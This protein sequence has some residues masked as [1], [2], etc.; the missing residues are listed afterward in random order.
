MAAPALSLMLGMVYTLGGWLLA[1][2]LFVLGLPFLVYPVAMG[3]ALVAPFV[4]VAFYAVSRSL[5]HGE[6]PTLADAWRAVAD[7][8]N[9]D[10]RWMALLTSFG[11]FVWM[12]SAAMITLSFFGA[13]AL[14]MPTLLHEIGTTSSGV[15]FLLVGHAVGAVIALIIFSASVISIPMLFDRDI[16][17]IT[18]IR[19]SVRLVR[20]NP[21][22]LALWCAMIAGAI[23]AS[24]VSGLL[25]LPVVLPII[26]YASWH[27]YRSAIKSA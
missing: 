26:G 8:K 15:L 14:D 3:F 6:R 20:E 10:V 2:L 18:A 1:A 25:L 16:D 13:A 12:D 5:G 23:V 7:A 17:A 19:T 9:R 4:A 21:A 27:L 11:F 24:V 22:P